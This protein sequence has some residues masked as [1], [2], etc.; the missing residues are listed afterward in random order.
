VK[1]KEVGLSSKGQS[2]AYAQRRIF[3]S[4]AFRDGVRAYGAAALPSV[5]SMSTFWVV[6]ESVE[7]QHVR[8]D[9]RV[10]EPVRELVQGAQRVRQRVNGPHRRVC[11]RHA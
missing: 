3:Y 11:K 1:K 2:K 10:S 6:E 5:P 4:G 9:Q 7:A 8:K